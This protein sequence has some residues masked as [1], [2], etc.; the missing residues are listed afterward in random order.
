MAQRRM[1]SKDV[2][3][4]D[5]FLEMPLSAQALYYHLGMD[6]DDD[7]FISSPKQ[8]TRMVGARDDDLRLLIAK[9]YIIPFDSGVCVVKHWKMN[10][11][12]RSDRRKDTIYQ[13]EAKQLEVEQNGAYLLTEKGRYTIG[14]PTV[15][16]AVDTWYTQDSIGEDSIGKINIGEVSV[17]ED[18]RKEGERGREAEKPKTEIPAP[19]AAPIYPAVDGSPD[20]YNSKGYADFTENLRAKF[21]AQLENQ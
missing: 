2:V 13:A 10:N 16:Q 9:G 1:F 14:I 4:T 21:R 18:R 5:K 11:Y 20:Y 8:I 12:L 3:R 7:G 19:R 17:G 6:A 15:T